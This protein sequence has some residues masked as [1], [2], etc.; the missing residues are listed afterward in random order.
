MYILHQFIYTYYYYYRTNICGICKK[1]F[2]YALTGIKVWTIRL[3]PSCAFKNII[4]RKVQYNFHLK[5]KH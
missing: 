5:K 2:T 3:C 4:S 1:E